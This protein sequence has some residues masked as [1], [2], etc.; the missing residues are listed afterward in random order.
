MSVLAQIYSPQGN[1]LMVLS[2]GA[3]EVLK[4][5]MKNYPADYDETYLRYTKNG[6]RVLAMAYKVV[7]KMGKEA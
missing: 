4:S 1:N 7:S 5:Y 6:A 2:K 3:P